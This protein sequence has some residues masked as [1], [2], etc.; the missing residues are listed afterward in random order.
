MSSTVGIGYLTRLIAVFA[1]RISTQIEDCAAPA[2]KSRLYENTEVRYN[3]AL[4]FIT[5]SSNL[6]SSDSAETAMIL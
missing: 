5:L 6:F 1:C 4:F 3:N 2:V